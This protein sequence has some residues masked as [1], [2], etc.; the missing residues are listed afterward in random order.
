M[1]GVLPA[2]GFYCRHVKGI[3]FRNVQLQT[4]QPDGRHAMV[5]DD[6]EGIVI[7]GLQAPTSSGACPPLRLTNTRNATLRACKL[8][9]ADGVFLQLE[10]AVTRG[11]RLMGNDWAQGEK[12][13]SAG[14]DVPSDGWSR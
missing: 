4:E 2:Y 1:F 12:A 11:I 7:D 13:I 8:Q 3:C 9:G 6:A 14:A 10:G 5:F